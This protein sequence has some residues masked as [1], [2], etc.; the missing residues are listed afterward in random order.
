MQRFVGL[1]ALPVEPNDRGALPSGFAIISE[2]VIGQIQ[3]LPER[4][5][6]KDSE[7]DKC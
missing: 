2:V 6:P 4:S 5:S 1:E 7:V 3:G